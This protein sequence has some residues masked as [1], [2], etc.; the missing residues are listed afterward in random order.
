MERLALEV[1]AVVDNHYK[2]KFTVPT[3]D[4][5]ENMRRIH[6]DMTRE[7]REDAEK[8]EQTLERFTELAERGDLS[9]EQLP[10]PLREKLRN[11]FRS[12]E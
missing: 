2:L 1:R 12:R 6:R 3:P 9:L 8:L 4:E 7:E 11:L 5:L 10:L